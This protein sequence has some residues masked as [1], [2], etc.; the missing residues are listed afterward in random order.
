VIVSILVF[1]LFNPLNPV[2]NFRIVDQ[3]RFGIWGHVY[4]WYTTPSFQ[5][6]IFIQERENQK[7]AGLVPSHAR[8]S[9]TE[10]TAYL[11]ASRVN[12]LDYYPMGILKSQ[13]VLLESSSG[14]ETFKASNVVMY[15]SPA[16][17]ASMTEQ[18]TK[19]LTSPC[20]RLLG[21]SK[22]TNVYLYKKI[23]EPKRQGCN[24]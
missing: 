20:Y 18:I 11:L 12:K 24:P 23:R 16:N 2:A 13:Y 1:L 7:L 19:L 14:N 4:R 10:S 22:L 21:H 9:V 5:E 8:V 15:S 17:S 3:Q 6:S